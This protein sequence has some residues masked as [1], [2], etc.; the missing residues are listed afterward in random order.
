MINAYSQLLVQEFKGGL[1]SEASTCVKFI[2]DGTK[3]MR[4]LLSDLLAYTQVTSEGDQAV[5]FVD[6]NQV[7]QKALQNCKMATEETRATITSECPSAWLAL[8]SKFASSGRTKP[9]ILM[10][11]LLPTRTT[12]EPLDF[13][14]GD[15]ERRTFRP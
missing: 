15:F 2:S 8:E 9:S 12:G 10:K 3:R 1:G 5:E 6:V 4:E 14:S 7:F 13:R 11:R